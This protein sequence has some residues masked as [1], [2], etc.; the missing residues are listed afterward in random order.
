MAHWWRAYDE[1][2]DD[3]KL[4]RLSGEDFKAWFN[5]CCLTSA[6]GGKLPPPTDIAF[7]LRMKPDKLTRV[8]ETLRAAGLIE[9]D[10]TGH[11]PHNWNGRQFKSDVSTER[12]KQHRERQR[13][14][15]SPNDETPNETKRNVDATAS[16]T[17]PDTDSE[18]ETDSE[19]K[20]ESSSLRSD[21][22]DWPKDFREQFWS[23]Y[24]KKTGKAGAI[25][26]LEA[27]RRGSTVTFAALMAGVQR[28]I[29]SKP[30]PKFTKH[31]ETWLSKGCWDDGISAAEP[32]ADF[33]RP[34][35]EREGLTRE[36]WRK[37]QGVGSDKAGRTQ[38]RSSPG[39]VE[40]GSD[41]PQE[42]PLSSGATLRKDEPFSQRNSPDDPARH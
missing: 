22:T 29:D 34:P 21:S 10:E 6:N 11:R 40:N 36:E 42:L 15:S 20:K 25:K 14:V 27:V 19:R 30:E 17:A 12:V 3:P 13:N 41:Q 38:V 24:P 16:E 8:M 23:A 37:L 18:A 31:P 4:Q 5:L 32:A 2:A 28:Y 9:E 33:T 7:K 35:W 1:A 39:M 26:K